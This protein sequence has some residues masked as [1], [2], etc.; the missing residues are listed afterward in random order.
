M[1]EFKVT[2]NGKVIDR[3]FFQPSFTKN[4]VRNTLI[5]RDGYS[6]EIEVI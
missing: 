3:V 4:E 1:K 2:I 5:N 6:T